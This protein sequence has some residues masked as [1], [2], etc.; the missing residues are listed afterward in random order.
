MLPI[1][2][3]ILLFILDVEVFLEWF[4]KLMRGGLYSFGKGIGL[5]F[6]LLL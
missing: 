1:P 3:A 5:F 4:L 6:E 2:F